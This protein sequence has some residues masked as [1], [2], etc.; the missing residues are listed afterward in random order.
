MASRWAKP[1][2]WSRGKTAGIRKKGG[3]RKK[4]NGDEGNRTLNPRL[5]KAV[6]C[7]LSYVPAGSLGGQRPHCDTEQSG[8]EATA[9]ND[10]S[11]IRHQASGIR[12]K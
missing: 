2:T 5:A 1:V 3:P 10:H 9:I 12:P 8:G 11:I 6:L 4:G 7:Q